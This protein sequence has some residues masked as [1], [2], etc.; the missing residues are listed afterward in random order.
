MIAGG[1]LER[2]TRECPNLFIQTWHEGLVRL[3]GAHWGKSLTL[4][5]TRHLRLA[6]AGQDRLFLEI[7]QV[8]SGMNSLVLPGPPITIR[9]FSRLILTRCVVTSTTASQPG[10][11]RPPHRGAFAAFAFADLT[12]PLSRS[13]SVQPLNRINLNCLLRTPSSATIAAMMP[14]N[15]E[16]RRMST[17]MQ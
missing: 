14:G 7:V 3:I 13:T 15:R 17:N 1:R 9:A 12:P 6:Q 10:R 5:S 8:A 16:G 4:G 2:L 11:V